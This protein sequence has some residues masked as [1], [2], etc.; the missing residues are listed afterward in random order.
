VAQAKTLDSGKVAAQI[1]GNKFSTVIGDLQ[2]DKKGDVSNSKYVF[3]IWN[4][5]EYKEEPSI[6]PRS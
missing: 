1:H 4:N 2:Y 5:G 3:Y 6:G